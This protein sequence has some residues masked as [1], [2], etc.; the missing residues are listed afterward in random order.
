MKFIF[1]ILWLLT[2]VTF[3][4]P[5]TAVRWDSGP[6]R[7][8]RITTVTKENSVGSFVGAIHDTLVFLAI[9]IKILQDYPVQGWRARIG[10][11]F[12]SRK[13]THIFR[14]VLQTGQLYYL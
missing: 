11:F 3:L 2:F 10:L 1:S 9:T 7:V 13:M 5:P 8:C 14:V 4:A 6:S 12:D